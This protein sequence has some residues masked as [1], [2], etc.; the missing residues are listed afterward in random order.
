MLSPASLRLLLQPFARLDYSDSSCRSN[1]RSLMA[2]NSQLP[3]ARHENA[4]GSQ[5]AMAWRPIPTRPQEGILRR[6]G[7]LVEKARLLRPHLGSGLVSASLTYGIRC[8]SLS[9]EER[10][11]RMIANPVKSSCT[12]TTLQLSKIDPSKLAVGAVLRARRLRHLKRE[13]AFSS[14]STARSSEA[15]YE[16]SLYRISREGADRRWVFGAT[17]AKV[18]RRRAGCINYPSQSVT[19]FRLSSMV[20]ERCTRLLPGDLVFQ[21]SGQNTIIDI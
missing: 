3:P 16:R 14:G 12:S 21:S 6:A 7:Q 9:C 2:P 11:G 18:R 15:R 17:R 20:T 8:R 19:A 5:A 10:C 13:T 4:A 1:L